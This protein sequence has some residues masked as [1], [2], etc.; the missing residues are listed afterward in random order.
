MIA[1]PAAA[2]TESDRLDE[3][4][5]MLAAA[6]ASAIDWLN[7]TAANVLEESG[8]SVPYETKVDGELSLL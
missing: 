4:P 2:Q 6:A 7:E 1:S 8:T 3:T 5:A